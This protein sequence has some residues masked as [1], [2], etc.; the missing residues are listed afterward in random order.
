M[1]RPGVRFRLL[2]HAT[3]GVPQLGCVGV[4]LGTLAGEGPQDDSLELGSDARVVLARRWRV[5]DQ[6]LGGDGR[7]GFALEWDRG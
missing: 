1:E 7:D 4:P 3:Q 6:A 5:L 2:A